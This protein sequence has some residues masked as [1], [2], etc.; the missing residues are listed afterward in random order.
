MTEQQIE[1]LDSIRGLAR[2][3]YAET[4]WYTS[5][6]ES[7]H[8]SG[9]IHAVVSILSA[10]GD[11]TIFKGSSSPILDYSVTLEQMR[12]ELAGWLAAARKEAA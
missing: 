7:R 3:I 6:D 11:L 2:A 4:G 12:D 10:Q 1:L 5:C 8:A 9:A